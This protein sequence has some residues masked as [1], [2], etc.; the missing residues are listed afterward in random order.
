MLRVGLTGG[1]ASGKSRVL[2]VLGSAGCFVLDLDRVAHDVMAPGGA[3]YSRVLEAFGEG[4][5]ASDRTIDRRRLGALKHVV[6]RHHLVPVS[7]GGR[8]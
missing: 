4:I 5:L 2:R 3:A 7:L 8:R 6:Q 1:I